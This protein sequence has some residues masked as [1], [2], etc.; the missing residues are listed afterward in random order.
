MGGSPVPTLIACADFGEG[1]GGAGGGAACSG[2]LL[3][4]ATCPQPNLG[5][6]LFDCESGSCAFTEALEPVGA[7][8]VTPGELSIVDG[9]LEMQPFE[10]GFFTTDPALYV[11]TPEIGGSFLAVTLVQPFSLNDPPGWPSG[12]ANLAGLVARDAACQNANECGLWTKF[13]VGSDP[14]G[15]PGWVFASSTDDDR[16]TEPVQDQTFFS[17]PFPGAPPCPGPILVGLCGLRSTEGI[18]L[19]GMYAAPLSQNMANVVA[20]GRSWYLPEASSVEVGMVAA[21]GYGNAAN[22]LRARFGM[23]QLHSNI[24]SAEDCVATFHAVLSQLQAQ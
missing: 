10:S 21:S 24:G 12:S 23:F 16:V 9:V 5:E 17:E 20:N 22:D 19:R 3:Y 14:D 15:N 11:F 4:S 13:E 7:V 1:E 2:E 8:S 18:A 6:F